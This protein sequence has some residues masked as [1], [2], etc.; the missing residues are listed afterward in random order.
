MRATT[1]F[2][3][4]PHGGR[5]GTED[6]LIITP[7]A[8]LVAHRSSAEQVKNVVAELERRKKP[9]AVNHPACGR[10]CGS[11]DCLEE[12]ARFQVMRIVVNPNASLS[13]QKHFHRSEHWTGKGYCGSDTGER[14]FSAH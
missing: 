2:T 7:D 1:S 11:Y 3:H 9:E 5:T 14:D 13:L 4:R 8:L 10:P 6:L 12:G